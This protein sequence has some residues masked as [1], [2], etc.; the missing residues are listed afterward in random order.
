VVPVNLLSLLGGRRFQSPQRLVVWQRFSPA[1]GHQPPDSIEYSAKTSHR[2]PACGMRP[3]HVR[4]QLPGGEGV[5]VVQ[6]AVED[7][8]TV[9]QELRGCRR[10]WVHDT[11]VRVYRITV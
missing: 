3:V 9:V 11:A 2:A 6:C 8:Q 10:R 1:Y 4:T 5:I 7:L